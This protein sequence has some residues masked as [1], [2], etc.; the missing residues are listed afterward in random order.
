MLKLLIFDFDVLYEIVLDPT[1]NVIKNGPYLLINNKGQWFLS[2]ESFKNY[3]IQDG[4]QTLLQPNTF[5]RILLQVKTVKAKKYV[6]YPNCDLSIGPNSLSLIQIFEPF[7]KHFNFVIKDHTVYSDCPFVYVNGHRYYD[8]QRIANGDEIIIGSLCII[9][10]EQFLLISQSDDERDFKV[11]LKPL[12]KLIINR[13]TQNYLKV[14]K[15]FHRYQDNC[16]TFIYELTHEDL[17]KTN[18]NSSLNSF[19][20]IQGLVMSVG[21]LLM[22]LFNYHFGKANGRSEMEL[23]QLLIMPSVMICGTLLIPLLRMLYLIYKKH[24]NERLY[25]L[26]VQNKLSIFKQQINDD[27]NILYRYNHQFAYDL[28]TNQLRLK[29]F[30]LYELEKDDYGFKQLNL[31]AYFKNL[32]IKYNEQDFD[33][34]FNLQATKLIANY[35]IQSVNLIVDLRKYQ[36]IEIKGREAKTIQYVLSLIGKLAI[37]H[38]YEDLKIAI[39]LKTDSLF[40]NYIKNLR[41]FYYENQRLIFMQGED[42]TILEQIEQELVIFDFGENHHWHLNSKMT[43]FSINVGDNK[44]KTMTIDLD[45]MKI[46]DYIINESL[47]FEYLEALQD[48]LLFLKQLPSYV[49]NTKKYNHSETI[50]LFDMYGKNLNL[51]QRYQSL[52]DK[53]HILVGLKENGAILK[54]DLSE[55][56]IGPHLLITG[57]TGSG[58]SELVLTI[59]LGIALNYT[60]EEASI[61]LI[62]YKGTGLKEALSYNEYVLPHLSLS[63]TNLNPLEFDRSLKAFEF[64]LLKRE[65]LF[66]RLAELAHASIMN[67]K[68]YQAFNQQFKLENLSEFFIVIDEFAELKKERPDFMHEI[69]RVARVGRS[70]GFHLILVTQKLGGVIDQEIAANISARIALKTNTIEDSYEMINSK[71][72]FSI[73]HPGEFYVLSQKGLS[74]GRAIYT[75]AFVDSKVNQTVCIVDHR[76][77]QIASIKNESQNQERQISYLI[78]QIIDYHQSLNFSKSSIFLKPLQKQFFNELV[79]KYDYLFNEKTLLLGEYDDYANM[80]QDLLLCDLRKNPFLILHTNLFKCAGC[81]LNNILASLKNQFFHVVLVTYIPKRWQAYSNALEIVDANNREDLLFMLRRIEVF[82][83]PLMLL[84]DDYLILKD[85]EQFE[86]TLIKIMLKPFNQN[87]YLQ[88]LLTHGQRLPYRLLQLFKIYSDANSKDELMNVYGLYNEHSEEFV[89][90]HDER[91]IGFK[92]AENDVIESCQNTSQLVIKIPKVRKCIKEDKTILLGYTHSMRSPYY[93]QADWHCLFIS[94]YDE[95]LNKFQNIFGV[96]DNYVYQ[97][98]HE[99]KNLNG[100]DHVVWLGPHLK[101]Q[102][103]IMVNIKQD[104]TYEQAYIYDLNQKEVI[105]LVNE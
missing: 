71:E 79:V 23:L 89:Y 32:K 25:A 54:F 82:K 13:Q 27:L 69:N 3:L 91:L 92:M 104:L 101:D 78:K 55:A 62:D 21:L 45:K 26:K 37:S 5:Y 77:N 50:T 88:L 53:S 33:E 65:R 18:A 35:Q 95:L 40:L 29:Q 76:L 10:N 81:W 103:L 28:K 15:N 75:R 34:E 94:W 58:K 72:A 60:A 68:D 4:Y 38:N 1:Q 56:G 52:I 84:I 97:N 80:H 61:A 66:K 9:Y 39:I 90:K 49:L 86:E 20:L 57:S 85:N 98:Y 59:L 73:K 31:G 30:E 87:F 64:E 47:N 100:F 11:H 105:E 24:H 96:N 7:F 70:L 12:K 17:Q 93:L 22:S 43:L 2:G 16:P 6:L 102:F 14:V 41:H 63:L 19:N 42:C 99:V 74:F 48:N 51:A 44:N 46:D 67:L 36:I 83:E 8:Y